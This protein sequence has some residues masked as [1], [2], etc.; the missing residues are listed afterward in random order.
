VAMIDNSSQ[1]NGT[2]RCYAAQGS[3][4]QYSYLSSDGHQIFSVYN[5]RGIYASVAVS[6]LF[7]AMHSPNTVEHYLI[8]V[9]HYLPVVRALYR[10]NLLT[11]LFPIDIASSR[12]WFY[13]GHYDL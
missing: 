11:H 4:F 2:W 9:S 8:Q 7:T 10:L 5:D 1:I 6:R 13:R 3:H 12:R